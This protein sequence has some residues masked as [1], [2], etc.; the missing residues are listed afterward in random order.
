MPQPREITVDLPALTVAALEWGPDDGP[1]ALCLHGFP[2]T[3]WTWR[4]LGPVLAERGWRVVAP[5]TRGYAPTGPAPDG[6]YRVGALITDALDLGRALGV[7]DRAVLVGHDWGALTSY[8][9]TAH[10]PRMFRR[11]VAMAVPP[12]TAISETARANW[13]ISGSQVLRSWYTLFN[14]LPAVPERVFDPLVRLLWRRW[15]PGYDAT[16]DLAL[17]AKALPDRAHRTAA[18]TYYRHTLLPR[19]T[20]RRYDAAHRDWQRPPQVPT[21]YLHGADDGC[22]SPGFAEHAQRHLPAG[23]EVDVV[24]NA[25]HFF[26]LEKPNDV[27]EPF[28]S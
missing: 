1:L 23:S 25:G 18:L 2:D 16:D 6:D 13:R 20:S 15:S 3:A 5:F 11:N 22:M 21:L 4:H 14:Q 9:A 26:H 12:I 19:G 24:A 8:G 17:L 27:N 10:E 7:D 28:S